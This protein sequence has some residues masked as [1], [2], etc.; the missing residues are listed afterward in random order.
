[1]SI[2]CQYEF[3]KYKSHKL[4]HVS[5]ISNQKKFGY[6][7]RSSNKSSEIEYPISNME[8]ASSRDFL[9]KLRQTITL[10]ILDTQPRKILD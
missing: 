6:T 1:M 8:Y 4:P 2:F 3:H 7:L 10:F 9:Y 5:T